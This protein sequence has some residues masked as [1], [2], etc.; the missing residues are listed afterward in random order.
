MVT[1]RTDSG[2][3]LRRPSIVVALALAFALS[4]TG[5][6]TATSPEAAIAFAN[7][8]RA[9]YGIPPLVLDQSLLKP[10]CNP[11][12]HEIASPFDTWTAT[13]SP[14]DNAPWHEALLYDP[15]FVAAAYGEYQGFGEE[16][17][18]WACMWFRREHRAFLGQPI[19]FFWSSEATGPAAVP[20]TISAAERPYTPAEQA[21][22]PNPTGPNIVVDAT[23]PDQT[24]LVEATS[25][26]V[27][28]AAGEA[29]PVHLVSRLAGEAVVLVDK[30]V[31]PEAD[32]QAAVQWEVQPLFQVPYELTQSFAFTT[33][34][35][36]KP[37]PVKHAVHVPT[38][39]AVSLRLKVHGRTARLLA[40]PALRGHRVE[41]SIDRLWVPC[42][43][44]ANAKRCTWVRKG[45]GLRLSRR[46]KRGIEVRFTP[47]GPWEKVV[48]SA[49]TKGF[50]SGGQSYYEGR[51][52][53]TVSGPK[54]KHR[55][56]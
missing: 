10:E 46:V 52:Y 50:D 49:F 39:H 55:A 19:S 29:L 53:A 1:T 4:F 34:P 18:T 44:V 56:R 17:G 14:W 54:P 21:K 36:P 35:A 48:I 26:T 31:A 41:F 23:V 15:E 13:S 3:G 37:E 28:T 5:E 30:P 12:D 7:Q 2:P 43:V 40:P 25:A 27:R 51:A 11:E 32:F 6:A 20:P 22:V 33:G 38:T 24:Y 47:P 8:Q 42:A 45:H 9:A 16:S